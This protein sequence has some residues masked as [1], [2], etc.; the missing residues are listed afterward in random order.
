V[1]DKFGSTR[2]LFRH[3]APTTLSLVPSDRTQLGFAGILGPA[4][5]AAAQGAR[6][7]PAGAAAERDTAGTRSPVAA[8]GAAAVAGPAAGAEGGAGAGGPGGAGAGDP[9]GAA[10]ELVERLMANL[11]S[12]ASGSDISSLLSDMLAGRR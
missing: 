3:A 10:G 4:A 7:A 1:R 2:L 6:D 12:E 11:A 8:G 5:G 9:G